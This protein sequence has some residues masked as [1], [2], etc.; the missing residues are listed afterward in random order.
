MVRESFESGGGVAST[1]RELAW[2]A[3]REPCPDNPC[4]SDGDLSRC[5]SLLLHQCGGRGD[6]PYVIEIRDQRGFGDQPNAD[7]DR[8]ITEHFEKIDS[9][10]GREII[11]K[12]Y[13]I[14]RAEARALILELETTE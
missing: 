3:G 1:N 5:L 9:F 8:L 14:D 11:L 7:Q 6:L 10:V 2:Y 4:P 12:L 13:A